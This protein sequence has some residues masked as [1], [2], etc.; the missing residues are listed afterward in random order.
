MKET[1]MSAKEYA[2]KKGISVQAVYARIKR[3]ELEHMKVGKV[4]FVINKEPSVPAKSII[5]I[6]DY[7]R[8]T[9]PSEY[10]NMLDAVHPY[11]DLMSPIQLSI[12]LQSESKLYSYIMDKVVEEMEAETYDGLTYPAIKRGIK[13]LIQSFCLTNLAFHKKYTRQE[14]V[15]LLLDQFKQISATSNVFLLNM[16]VNHSAL[17]NSTFRKHSYEP[18]K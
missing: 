3:G 8:L 11:N 2:D 6:L 9:L 17:S 1:L 14:A 12:V 4:Y 10:G 18:I 5:D 13:S 15:R 16:L 7:E